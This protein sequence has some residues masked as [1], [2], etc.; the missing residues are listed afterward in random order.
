MEIA[1]GLHQVGRR[2]VAR[3]VLVFRI[4]HPVV[5]RYQRVAG[6]AADEIAHRHHGGGEARLVDVADHQG[7]GVDE[8]VAR[9]AALELQLHQRVERLP[10]R[11]V[12]EALP[13]VL[14]GVPDGL[15]QAEHLGDAL[16]GKRRS[17]IAGAEQLARVAVH[18]DA[19]LIG[20]HIGQRRDVIGHLA[21]T[22][23]R[24]DF[25]EDLVQQRLHA[26]TRRNA[27]ANPGRWLVDARQPA[28]ITQ[29]TAPG[30]ALNARRDAAYRAPGRSAP[31]RPR[32]SPAPGRHAA[33]APGRPGSSRS[34]H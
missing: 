11:L 22:D 6:Q 8:G 18:R 31:R 33:A 24:A 13:D 16:H 10:G 14:A 23:Q 9:P 28:L 4:G 15:H 25:I 26:Q 20:R 34:G 19:Q 32:Q 12:A 29:E 17:R 1:E 30:G 27:R 3:A 2:R 21:L 7:A 5:H